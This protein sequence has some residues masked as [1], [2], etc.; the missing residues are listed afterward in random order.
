MD[1]AL[2]SM[3]GLGGPA[4]APAQATPAQPAGGA[5]SD[6]G[7]FLS[8]P[9]GRAALISF[10]LQAMTGGYGNGV[11]QLGAALGAGAQGAGGMDKIIYDRAQA[12]KE[13][14]QKA[15][16]GA[17]NRAQS[18]TNARIA[19]DSRNEVAQT[20]T[21]GMLQRA[22]LIH[23]PQNNQEM[24]IYSKAAADYMKKEKDNQLLSKKPDEQIRAEADAWAKSVLA[25]ARDASGVRSQGGALPSDGPGDIGGASSTGGPQTGGPTGQGGQGTPGAPGNASSKP[26]T[27]D[28][29]LA[30]K[31]PGPDQF[32]SLIQT[33]QGQAQLLALR[34]N[35]K[36]F[37]DEYNARWGPQ[38]GTAIGGAFD[39]LK[40]NWQGALGQ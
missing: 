39:A 4:E 32:R 33:P 26:M 12:E 5:G 6:W 18:E 37:I 7:S 25:N 13:M 14:S 16:E 36:P 8:D 9:R 27:L 31:G 28:S 22:A 38:Q 35:I 29:L 19:A 24:N 2:A 21:E 10:G 23:G 40:R 11:Q 1:P 17:A 3:F 20:R 15:S 34:P 30:E